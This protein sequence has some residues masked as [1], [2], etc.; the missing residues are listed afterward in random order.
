[1]LGC[2]ER[3]CRFYLLLGGHRTFTENNPLPRC[4]AG[5]HCIVPRERYMAQIARRG[6]FVLCRKK[7]G[8]LRIKIED[9]RGRN[10][11]V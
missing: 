5:P 1:M 2:N 6:R 11:S 9:T 8:R 4:L 10:D 3:F 7:E